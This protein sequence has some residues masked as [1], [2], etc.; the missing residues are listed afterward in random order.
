MTK[1]IKKAA[2]V[3]SVLITGFAGTFA[4][5]LL[6]GWTGLIVIFMALA[7][8]MW[9]SGWWWESHLKRPVLASTPFVSIL[10]PAWKSAGHIKKTLLSAKDIDWPNKEIIVVNDSQDKTGAICRSMGIRCM[11]SKTRQ[12]K[13][14]SLNKA[15]KLAKGDILFFIDSDTVVQPDCLEKMLPRFSE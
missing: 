7:I 15:A 3:A 13:A 5:L 6:T 4:F 14:V 10:I 12:G 1:N 11:Q 9:F 8:G 2:K